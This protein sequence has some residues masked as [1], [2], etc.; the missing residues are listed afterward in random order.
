VFAN[1]ILLQIERVLGVALDA[2]QAFAELTV[3]RLAELAEAAI[4]ERIE[5]M[6]EEEAANLVAAA[7]S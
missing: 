7:N 2:E 1:Q 4:L 5:A 3:A 6:S